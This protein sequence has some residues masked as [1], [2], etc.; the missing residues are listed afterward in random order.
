MNIASIIES[1]DPARPALIDGDQ[2]ISFGELQQQAAAVRSHLIARHI[3]ADDRV[4]IVAGNEPLFVPCLLGVMGIG[5]R[6]IPVPHTNPL[7]ELQRKLATL[8]P[9]LV[10]VCPDARWLLD[11]PDAIAAPLIDVGQLDLSEPL[12]VLPI[13]NCEPDH[14]ALMML[15]SGVS[16]DAKTAMLT[17][18][19]LKSAQE[20]LV[21]G[22]NHGLV[23]TDIVL[24][25][26]PLSHIFGLNAVLL[27]ALRCGA[28]SILQRRFDVDASL[29]LITEHG[30]SV[31]AGAPPMWRRWS[32]LDAPAG[33]FST[34]RIAVSGAAA[35]SKDVQRRMLERHGVTVEEGYG[36]TETASVITSSLGQ[37]VRPGSVG[38]PIGDIEVVLV[39]PDGRAVDR[40]DSGEIV[41]RGTNIFAG[42]FDSPEKTDLALTDSGWFWTGDV[43]LMDA[44]GY[45]YIVDRVKDLIIVSGFNVYPAEVEAVLKSH[46]SV[47]GAIAIGEPDEHTDETVV[48]YVT[49]DV[50]PDV[51]MAYSHEQL[52]RYKC[53][54]QIHVVDELPIAMTGKPIRRELRS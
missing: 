20:S 8:D 3:S 42:Y 9:A 49:G 19:N 50:D 15:T 4:I 54:T 37:D 43:G 16:G 41:V 12:D 30:I 14:I 27:T 46:E 51:L 40:G 5:A 18:A 29:D 11:D 53:P 47:T 10:L 38:K 1:H 17:H 48:A 33:T 2:V 39:E 52:S 21:G 13:V 34:V 25:S 35:L 36:M 31:L 26:L 28:L 7:P 24:A 45:L 22:E 32:M 6:A 23:A 44:D